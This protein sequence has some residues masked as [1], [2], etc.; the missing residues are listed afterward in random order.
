MNPEQMVCAFHPNRPTTLRCNRCERPICTR[1]AVLTPVGYRCKACVKGQQAAFET[2]R[3]WDYPAAFLI[4]AL[5]VGIAVGL[6]GFIGYWGFLVAPAV[7]G[8][9]AEG[10]R[11]AVG[12][13]RSRRLPLA[14]AAGGALAVLFHVLLA[15]FG[16][17]LIWPVAYGALMISTLVYRIRGI[18]I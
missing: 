8:G 14:A 11:A 10:V 15:G 16:L 6:L 5:G 2:A 13:R 3:W 9:L 17:G 4:S 1:C 12:R 18:Y 7:G